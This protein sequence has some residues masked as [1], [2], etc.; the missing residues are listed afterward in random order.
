MMESSVS[1]V[2]SVPPEGDF[3]PITKTIRKRDGVTVQSFEVEKIRRAVSKAWLSEYPEINSAAVERVIR[4]VLS[5]IENV[6]VTVEDVQDLVELALMKIAPKVAK[7]YIIYREERAKDIGSTSYVW[8][9]RHDSVTRP[10]HADLDGTVQ[11]WDNPP[12]TDK[13]AGRRCNPGCDYNCRCS[14]SPIVNYIPALPT[15]EPAIN[16]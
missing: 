7:H 12:I 15:P 11:Y 8:R 9:A 14:A 16:E 5:S 1:S 4:L 10:D 2:S 6:E 3:E 13:A